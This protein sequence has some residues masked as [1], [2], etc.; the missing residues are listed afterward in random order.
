MTTLAKKIE[1]IAK[2]AHLTAPTAAKLATETKNQILEGIAA[3]LLTRQDE[4]IKANQKDIRAATKN[5]MTTAMID[6]L[7]LDAKRIQAMAHEL[8]EVKTLPDPVGE[9]VKRWTRP[10]GLE[11]SRVRI[12]LGV[13]GIIYESRPNVTIDAACLCLKSGNV[14]VLRGGSEA[15]HS[16]IFLVKLIRD[17]LKSQGIDQDIVQILPMTDRKAMGCLV[18]QSAFIDLMIPRGGESLMKWMEEHSRIPVVKHDKG[19]CHVYV[20]ESAQVTM[21]EKI[22]YNAKV[23]RPGVCNAMETLLVHEK[24]A[25]VF[26]PS[27]IQKYKE[28]GVEVRGDE[29][30]R[31]IGP[32]IKKATK[33]DWATEYLDL[34]V[35]IRVVSSVDEAIRHIQKYGSTHTES[36]VTEN[37]KNA[38]EFLNRL[39]SSVVLWNASTRFNDGGQLGLGAEIGISTTKLHAF[40]PMGLEELTTTKFVVKGRGQIRE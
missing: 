16:N 5:K 38:E 32:S 7:I 18:K 25:P 10:N 28:A 40:G 19:V 12:P 4:I 24:I 27:M 39:D 3:A 22:A 14:V 9:I 35:S 8:R 6:R 17:V 37:P 21:A 29:K 30:A 15:I 20:D 2:K 34:I 23:Q 11:V 31:K 26:L 1:S 36:I 13:I 33:K